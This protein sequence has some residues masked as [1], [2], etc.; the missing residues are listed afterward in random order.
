MPL[1]KMGLTE[2]Q[3][4]KE[5]EEHETQTDQLRRYQEFRD[6]RIMREQISIILEWITG[7]GNPKNGFMWRMSVLEVKFWILLSS[8][9]GIGYFIWDLWK[10][11]IK[12]NMVG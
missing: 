7:N 4:Q 10:C 5:F 12:K 6:R 9:G 8:I 2:E 3:L 11:M 1:R